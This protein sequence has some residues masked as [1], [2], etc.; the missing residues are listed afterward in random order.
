MAQ[1]REPL[2]EAAENLRALGH[3]VRLRILAMLGT[4]SLCVCQ[5]QGALGLAASTVSSHLAGLRRAGYVTERRSGKWV[6]YQLADDGPQA[7]LL[8]QALRFAGDDARLAADEKNVAAI[9]R[10]PLATFCRTGLATAPGAAARPRAR[11]AISRR[12]R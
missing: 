3:P 8:R 4:G 11:Q 5:I 7:G 9:R 1:V 10:V 2:L 6:H 12:A